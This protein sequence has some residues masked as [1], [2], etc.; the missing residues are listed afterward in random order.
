M[1]LLAALALLASSALASNLGI[2]DVPD[3]PADHHVTW[4]VRELRS[5]LGDEIA[6]PTSIVPMRYART[7]R[8]VPGKF[9]DADGHVYNATEVLLLLD[10]CGD[11]CRSALDDYKHH[12]RMMA[13]WTVVGELGFLFFLP[14]GI[15]GEVGAVTQI[16]PMNRAFADG[17]RDFNRRDAVS[18]R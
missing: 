6:L 3:A 4:K 17:V 10:E 9:Y 7:G 16:A 1:T 12:Q 14:V 5:G 15:V 11:A 13:T 8:I 18:S 2:T